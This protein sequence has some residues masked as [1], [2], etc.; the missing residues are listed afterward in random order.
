MEN[1][2]SILN[3]INVNDKIEAKN[4]LSYLSW[5]W[6]WGEVKKVHPLAK[7]IDIT[8]RQCHPSS[9]FMPPALDNNVVRSTNCVSRAEV[10]ITAR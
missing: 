6:A 5:A 9:K 3:S 10:T 8:C 2:F 7:Y 4:G 1:Y